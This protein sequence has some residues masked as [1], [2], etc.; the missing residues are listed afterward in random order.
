MENKEIPSCYM[1]ERTATTR[2]HVPPKSFFPE[3]YRTNLVTVPL[4]IRRSPCGRL[5]IS[6][7]Q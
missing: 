6:K 3:G 7:R 1:C 2:E 4:L 5:E